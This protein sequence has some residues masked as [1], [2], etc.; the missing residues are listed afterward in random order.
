LTKPGQVVSANA[1]TVVETVR[2]ADLG[3][4][5]LAFRRLVKTAVSN[6]TRFMFWK[7]LDSGIG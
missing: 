6:V 2:E 4:S 3:G 1:E 7:A 5:Y